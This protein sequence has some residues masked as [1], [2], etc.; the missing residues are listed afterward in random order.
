MIIA[1]S[2]HITITHTHN[3]HLH[4]IFCVIIINKTHK[5]IIIQ[6]HDT[7]KLGINKTYL[8]K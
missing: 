1:I 6:E 5:I 2:K 8:N 3:I 7:M 4:T